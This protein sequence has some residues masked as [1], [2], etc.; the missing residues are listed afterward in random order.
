M[1]QNLKVISKQ[2]AR[3]RNT[4]SG[5]DQ[6]LDTKIDFLNPT[7]FGFFQMNFE[8][9]QISMNDNGE[10]V[11]T[12][13]TKGSGTSCGPSIS[14]SIRISTWAPIPRNRTACSGTRTLSR[15]VH[16]CRSRLSGGCISLRENGAKFHGV[17]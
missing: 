12:L 1:F 2:A 10:N 5:V 4:S 16:L 15:S 13:F 6:V 11:P 7:F 3:W 8:G 17:P 9:G 14:I